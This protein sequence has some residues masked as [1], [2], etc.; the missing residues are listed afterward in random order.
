MRGWGL[1]QKSL[2]FAFS[3]MKS[4]TAGIADVAF[5]RAASRLARQPPRPPSRRA[6]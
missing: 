1:S 6:A 3:E 5:A 4:P 2:P